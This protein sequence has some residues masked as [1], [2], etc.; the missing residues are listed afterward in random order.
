MQ[1]LDD[2]QLKGRGFVLN[3]NVNVIM[4]VYKVND[5][6]ASSWV[7]LLEKYKNNKSIINIQNDDQFV[8]VVHPSTP[9]SR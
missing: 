6:Q 9:F 1:K 3:G 5:I 2:E 4:E 8:F 7:E